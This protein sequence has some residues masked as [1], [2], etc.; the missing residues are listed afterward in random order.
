MIVLRAPSFAE[1]MGRVEATGIPCVQ[2]H[3][4]REE[5]AA[6]LEDAGVRV[7]RVLEAGMREAPRCA[8]FLAKEIAPVHLDVGGGGSGQTFDWSDL[9]GLDLEH[10][11]VA[12]GITPD[13]VGDLLAYAPWGI[14]VSSG[15]EGSPGIKD[16]ARLAALFAAISAGEDES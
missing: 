2:L 3:S 15:V 5:V 10:V 11:F 8:A 14:D 7:H 1:A 12:G 16:H 13:N 4:Y 9:A 6:P